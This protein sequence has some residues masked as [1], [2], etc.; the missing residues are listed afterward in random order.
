VGTLDIDADLSAEAR[1]ALEG[2][3]YHRVRVLARDGAEDLPEDSPLD[4]IIATVGCPDV[5]PNR[6]LSW[7]AAYVRQASQEQLPAPRRS[8]DSA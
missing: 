3:G 5:S 4:R 6:L 1:G 2:A 8:G 7:V